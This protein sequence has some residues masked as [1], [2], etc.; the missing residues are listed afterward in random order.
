MNAAND[1]IV[2]SERSSEQQQKEKFRC[3]VGGMNKLIEKNKLEKYFEKF[4]KVSSILYPYDKK[5]KKPKGYAIVEFSNEDDWRKCI[6]YKGHILENVLLQV[7]NLLTF[8]QARKRNEEEQ[9][10]KLFV[11]SLPKKTTDEQLL[12]YFSK[13]GEVQKVERQF[14]L[15]K[16]KWVFKQFA[17]VIMKNE[18]DLDQILKLEKPDFY[19]KKITIQRAVAKAKSKNESISYFSQENLNIS[20]TK[21]DKKK[22]FKSIFSKFNIFSN[23]ASERPSKENYRINIE[24]FNESI[25]ILGIKLNK[26]RLDIYYE[27]KIIFKNTLKKE[28]ILN[29]C[30]LSKIKKKIEKR[31]INLNIIDKNFVYIKIEK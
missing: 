26:S 10:R 25:E 9:K 6:G 2:N 21:K 24:S 28:K 13:Y 7:E 14:G 31:L 20:R 29:A 30:N 16:G 3:F 5:C 15:K 1:N 4:G 11:K 18:K 19:G 8:E 23:E 12:T 17:F 27:E 22:R